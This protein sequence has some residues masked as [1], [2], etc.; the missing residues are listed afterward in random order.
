MLFKSLDTMP[1]TTLVVPQQVLVYVD[2]EGNPDDNLTSSRAFT[3]VG[4]G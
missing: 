3:G 2:P 4:L 1:R